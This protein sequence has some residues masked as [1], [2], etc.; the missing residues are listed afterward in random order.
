MD[1]NN[2][3]IVFVN[4]AT[5]YL[6]I[7]IVNAFAEHFERVAL[8]AGSVRV[9]DIELDTRVRWSKTV[10]YNRGNPRKKLF[11]W[12]SGTIQVLFLLLFKYRKFEIFYITVPPFAYLL[13]LILPNRF[14]ILVFDVYPDILKIYHIKTRSL[15]YRVWQN[16]NRKIFKRAYRL[17]TIGDGMAHL[18]EQYVERERVRVIPLWTGLAGAVRVPRAKNPW[19][20]KLGLEKKFI[21]QYSG[22]IGY[23]HN[24][25]VLIELADKMRNNRDCHFLIIGRGEKATRISR[26][27]HHYTLPNCTMLPFQPDDLLLYSLA[28]ADIGVVMLDETVANVSLPSKIYNLQAVGTPILGISPPETE[29]ARHL[30]R[31]GNGNCFGQ[32][33]IDGMERFIEGLMKERGRWQQMSGNSLAA[34]GGF[35]RLNAQKYLTDYVSEDI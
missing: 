3:N 5:G 31:Y 7:D 21:V 30:A 18:L 32:E 24:V 34:A 4:Q 10:R 16:W 13:S 35:T 23:T 9:Q 11:S 26:L 6:T 2:R 33:E 1:L 29:L 12:L 22:N 14:S 15:I 17:Y 8:I 25:E 20:K 27:I 19:L 28:A